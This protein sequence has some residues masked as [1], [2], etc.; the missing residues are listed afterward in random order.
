MEKTTEKEKKRG[1]IRQTVLQIRTSLEST[2]K[3]IQRDGRSLIGDLLIFTVGF[4]LSRCQILLGAR[5]LGIAY[6]SLLS[7]GVWPALLGTK[8]DRSHV[9]L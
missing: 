1:G 6:V 8:S 4:L 7:S 5:P 2:L 3:E 9:V